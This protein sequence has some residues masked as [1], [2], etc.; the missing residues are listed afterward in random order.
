MIACDKHE[1]TN[2]FV[3]IPEINY[4]KNCLSNI[5]P[6]AIFSKIT[7]NIMD[8]S[9]YNRLLWHFIH[10]EAKIIAY[11]KHQCKNHFLCIAEIECD[12]NCISHINQ[13]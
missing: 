9:N 5:I 10:F 13:C 12:N 6:S 3:C 7:L 8:G 11:D 2:H 1:S 4:N